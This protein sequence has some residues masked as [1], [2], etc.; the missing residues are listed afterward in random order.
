MCCGV[1]ARTVLISS[2][3]L[4]EFSFAI[5]FLIPLL[6][7]FRQTS[8]ND[9]SDDL[10][11]LL[12]HLP[13]SWRS[14]TFLAE[15]HL[16]CCSLPLCVVRGQRIAIHTTVGTSVVPNLQIVLG[17]LKWLC[18]FWDWGTSIYSCCNSNEWRCNSNEITLQPLNGWFNL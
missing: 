10:Q 4:A 18:K 9:N 3:F 7:C 5:K 13:K 12:Q 11:L 8:K 17:G 1:M 2:C 6:Y 14:W 16:Y 15:S